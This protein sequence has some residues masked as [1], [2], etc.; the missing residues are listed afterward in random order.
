MS[1]T[2]NSGPPPTAATAPS[3]GSGPRRLAMRAS[4]PM[5]SFLAWLALLI[6][7]P[8]V[9]PASGLLVAVVVF[10]VLD[11]AVRRRA[12][13]TIWIPDS[14][15]PGWNWSG[16][17]LVGAVL[18]IIPT[19]VLFQSHRL[20]RY[21]AD[22]WT[23]ALMACALLAGYALWRRAIV[24]IVAAALTV[25]VTTAAL[26]P[27]LSEVTNGDAALVA[28]LHAQRDRGA[29]TGLANMSIALVD[30]DAPVS[31]RSAGLGT[32]AQTPFEVGSITKAM[33]GL[34]LADA[35][36]RHEVRLDVPVSH[37]LPQLAGS[38]GGTVTLHE[39]ATH[40]AG[41]VDFGSTTFVRGAWKAPLG[42]S[43]TGTSMK[44]MLREVRE[45]TL[46]GRGT[47]LYS[48]LGAAT[49]GQAV[50]AAAGLS[51][52]ELMRT[53][54]FA[55]LRMNDTHIQM[56]QALVAGGTTASGLG[57]QPWLWDAYAP[58]GAAVS[59]AADLARL[60]AALLDG[61]APGVAALTPTTAT[62]KA[63]VSI[64]IFWV[65]AGGHAGPTITWHTGQTGGYSSYLGLDLAR[66]RAAVVL[67]DVAPAATDRLGL[68]LLAI[69][70]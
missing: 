65:T 4:A 47:W 23:A 41:Y 58:A 36:R 63:G 10:V 32:S 50:A 29:L 17:M 21:V 31:A 7:R 69:D 42:R 46:S 26:S 61:T 15:A 68:S 9:P 60:A 25:I 18:I 64:G 67:C 27:E 34:V 62:A 59:T 8:E 1:K 39:L 24:A 54:L 38:P 55:P 14:Q 33:T 13:R 52:P 40:T 44:Q 5:G 53:R 51:Y 66:R 2:A 37:Y 19:L 70:S 57:A 48:N 43:F 22:S 56:K 12:P 45:Q 3:G 11:V 28:Q 49:A 6:Y 35:V 20:D 30:P 16:K